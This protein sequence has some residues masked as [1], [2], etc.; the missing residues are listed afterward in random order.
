[1]HPQGCG[2]AHPQ[3]SG[4][5]HLQG[6]EVTHL[7]GGGILTMRNLADKVDFFNPN[8]LKKFLLGVGGFVFP[9]GVIPGP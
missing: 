9:N 2:V 4:V 7:Q 1:M 8:I 3:G 6:C 5:V